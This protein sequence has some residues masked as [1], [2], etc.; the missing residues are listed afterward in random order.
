MVGVRRLFSSNIDA[1]KGVADTQG[2][3][4]QERSARKEPL[5]RAT[6]LQL[7]CIENS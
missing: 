5:Q 6:S 1:Q 4:Q 7:F 3:D 2:K